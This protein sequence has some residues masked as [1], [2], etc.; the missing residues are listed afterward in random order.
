VIKLIIGELHRIATIPPKAL[1]QDNITGTTYL[2]RGQPVT[3]LVRWN[4]RGPRNVL[5]EHE[6]GSRVVRSFRG[7]RRLPTMMGVS[8]SIPLPPQTVPGFSFANYA[9]LA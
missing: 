7:L 8:R 1:K 6:G 2:L 4:G 3:V 5:I 9:I